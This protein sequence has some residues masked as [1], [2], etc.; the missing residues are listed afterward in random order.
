MKGVIT[1]DLLSLKQVALTMSILMMFYLFLGFMSMKNSDGSMS[2]FSIMALVINVMV[3]LSCAGYDE[4]CGW[5]QFGAALPVSKNQIVACRY[6]VNLMVMGFTTLVVFVGNMIFMACGGNASG[7]ETY[8]I[9]IVLSLFYVAIITPIIYKFGVQ[10]SRIIVIAAM[11]LPSMLVFA[12]AMLWNGS[13]EEESSLLDSL[14]RLASIPVI[15]AFIMASVIA[16]AV[17]VLSLLLSMKIYN[18]KEL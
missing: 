13:A 17:Y 11:L 2:Y 8:V 1:K 10:K 12:L 7:P 4:Q 15:P 14:D 9:P 16:V 18:H 6:L 5:D 3:P